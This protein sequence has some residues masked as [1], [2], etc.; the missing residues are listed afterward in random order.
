MGNVMRISNKE[1]Y[2]KPEERKLA[3]V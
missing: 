1:T 3:T 2:Y